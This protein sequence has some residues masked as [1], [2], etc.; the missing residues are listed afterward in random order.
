MVFPTLAMIE[1]DSPPPSPTSF[2]D[3][4]FDG[5]GVEEFTS[6][7]KRTRP[8]SNFTRS[9][10]QKKSG[11]QSSEPA[12]DI[13]PQCGYD[14]NGELP[15]IETPCTDSE[16]VIGYRKY[17]TVVEE[18]VAGFYPLSDDLFIVQAW[19]NKFHCV[20]VSFPL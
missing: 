5:P 1:V 8:I 17:V 15:G 12:D 18:E 9:K 7:V 20:K 10:K 6:P 16:Q 4:S 19:D 13:T 11:T 14:S 2:A 3:D